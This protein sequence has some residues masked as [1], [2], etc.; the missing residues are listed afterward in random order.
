MPA[1]NDSTGAPVSDR[2]HYPHVAPQ[3][4]TRLVT[5]TFEY[6]MPF[7]YAN[8]RVVRWFTP[9]REG[10]GVELGV[11]NAEPQAGLRD[12][13]PH[14][15]DHIVIEETDP[16]IRVAVLGSACTPPGYVQLECD[17][18][19]EFRNNWESAS[20]LPVRFRAENLWG[21]HLR[22]DALL[23][24]A[25]VE[26]KIGPPQG[27]HYE[28]MPEAIRT[29]YPSTRENP[30][31]V[32]SHYAENPLAGMSCAVFEI[33]PSRRVRVSGGSLSTGWTGDNFPTDNHYS[34]RT[35]RT[36]VLL[37]REEAAP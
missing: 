7:K 37:R 35:I 8:I 24:N 2:Y 9:G 1:E 36:T 26:P 33:P 15:A 32:K 18:V 13:L 34:F 21:M 11:I 5:E 6:D 25:A 4:K 3:K 30:W 12:P 16:I 14:E 28:A 31:H 23:A 27:A 22:V 17:P 10:H 29:L 20:A 19:P